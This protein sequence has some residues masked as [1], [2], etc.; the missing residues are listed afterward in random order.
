MWNP[1]TQKNIL[2]LEKIQNHGAHWVCG[3]RLN[4]HTSIWSKSSC[5]CYREL[6]Q[7]Y[8]PP[9]EIKYQVL[10]VNWSVFLKGILLTLQSHSLNNGTH[11]GCQLD[12]GTCICSYWLFGPLVCYWSLC[13]RHGCSWGVLKG[14]FCHIPPH[15]LTPPHPTSP[16]PVAHPTH[17]LL[18][19]LTSERDGKKYLEIQPSD[20]EKVSYNKN[21]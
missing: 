7:L 14:S 20:T 16:C 5:D 13:G 21:Q 17:P 12:S 11:G 3:S 19:I 4:P 10:N 18:S 6:H 1:H 15:P 8:F 9:V 2:A